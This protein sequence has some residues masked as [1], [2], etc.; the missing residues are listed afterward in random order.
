MQD[1]RAGFSP[2]PFSF[3][4]GDAHLCVPNVV[5]GVLLRYPENCSD[6]TGVLSL[7]NGKKRECNPAFFVSKGLEFKRTIPSGEDIYF[8]ARISGHFFL[9]GAA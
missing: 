2:R 1:E 6:S 7:Q 9:E 3:Y 8:F 5:S 4:V